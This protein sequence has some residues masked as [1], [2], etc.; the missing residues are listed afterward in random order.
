ML[1]LGTVG[2]RE[3]KKQ[4]CR[5]CDDKRKSDRQ[6]PVQGKIEVWAVSDQDR[7]CPCYYEWNTVCRSLIVNCLCSRDAFMIMFCSVTLDQNYGDE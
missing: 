7:E 6:R 2:K 1:V 4:Y 5:V 3:G